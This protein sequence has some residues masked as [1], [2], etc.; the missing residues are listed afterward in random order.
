MYN[1]TFYIYIYYSIFLILFIL[2]KEL[3]NIKDKEK[4]Y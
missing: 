4:Q 1:P 2:E 3:I